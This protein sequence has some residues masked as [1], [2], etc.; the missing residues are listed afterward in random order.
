[1]INPIT[2]RGYSEKGD[3]P[4]P[5]A[6]LNFTSLAAWM[7]D[8]WGPKVPRAGVHYLF[9]QPGAGK[10]SL[11]MVLAI[12]LALQGESCLIILT[13]RTE[14]AVRDHHFTQLLESIPLSRRAYVRER[15]SFTDRV[16]SLSSL[17]DFLL[18]VLS[19]KSSQQAGPAFV[20][21]DSVNGDGV[22]PCSRSYEGLYAAFRICRNFQTSLLAL[23]HI[24]K[25]GQSSGPQTIAHSVDTVSL[26]RVGW[27]RIYFQ[28]LKNRYFPTSADPTILEMDSNGC[29]RLS[30]HACSEAATTKTLVGG[31]DSAI[32]V[33]L[34]IP[35]IGK[36]PK[37]LCPG[38][39]RGNISLLLQ[40]LERHRDLSFPMSYFN[41]DIQ[42]VSDVGYQKTMHLPIAVGCLASM[43][44][45]EIPSG[46][47]F[48]G[49]MDL[50]LRL[51]DLPLAHR[52]ALVASLDAGE[53]PAASTIICPA[54]DA[55][56]LQ[57]AS[58]GIRVL[59]FGTF[60]EFVDMLR[61]EKA[62][63]LAHA[64]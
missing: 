11:S 19:S 57:G 59:G 45:F 26:M 53:L 22:H 37:I 40:S 16:T 21:L 3:H 23:G 42:L 49:S 29:L 28:T 30:P 2:K 39:Q 20:V 56:A 62:R 64:V 48:V 8:V 41:V 1:M 38:L 15:V 9:S 55:A 51:L 12:D 31:T 14:E 27:R 7:T 13:E 24:T 5:K 60:L 63:F 17:P 18:G 36:Q 10:S 52:N 54:A 4:S 50:N 46:V 25:A 32:Q 33:S 6:F 35:Q 47:Y 34:S 44:R 58:N 43:D 61:N